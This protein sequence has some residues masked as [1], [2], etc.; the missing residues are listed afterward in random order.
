MPASDTIRKAAAVLALTAAV[1]TPFVLHAGW[2]WD[3]DDYVTDN[4]ALTAPGGLRAI[5][6]DPSATPQYYP[7]TH[8]TFWV[9]AR[10]YGLR[11]AAFRAVNVG[12]HGLSCVQHP[13]RHRRRVHGR[14]KYG[15]LDRA[16]AAGVD[17]FAVRW[18]KRR[19]LRYRIVRESPQP[20]SS[21][22]WRSNL[23]AR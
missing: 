2:I 7:L 22:A 21:P 18:M 14:S 12:L 4:P 1:Y 11:P 13:V 20:V 17:L 3:D 19:R 16:R 5:W 6:T 8:T 9:E 10:L 15:I 23:H